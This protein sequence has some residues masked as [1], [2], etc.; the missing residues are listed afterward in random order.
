MGDST[1]AVRTR[2]EVCEIGFKALVSAL[3]RED[4]IQFIHYIAGNRHATDYEDGEIQEAEQVL[5]AMTPN[6]IHEKIMSMHE[7]DQQR[8]FL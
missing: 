7:P 5:P 6:E 1:M 8:S 3:G 4:A 2:D